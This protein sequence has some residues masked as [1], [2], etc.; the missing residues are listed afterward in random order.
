MM[1]DRFEASAGD[2]IMSGGDSGD[3]YVFGEGSG[4]DIIRENVTNILYGDVDT[5]EFG[6]GV[7]PTEVTVTAQRRGPDP[8]ARGSG[9][10]LTIDRRIRLRELVHLSRRRA[11]PLRRR[12]RIW[13][14]AD[15]QV[16]ARLD[17]RRRSSDRLR[18][19]R[20][21]STAAPA[22]TYLE[23]ATAA[24]PIASGFGSG[25]DIIRE[26]RH[27][28]QSRRRRPARSSAPAS[29]QRR[30]LQP[31]RQRSRRHHLVRATR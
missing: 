2:D 4:H 29:C 3:T 7:L 13:T 15:I 23:G 11:V 31:R 8:H 6:P 27:Q 19:R 28:F 14:K 10:T 20:H 18:Q 30:H 17:R 5:V 24:T 16:R 22:T 9:D 26:W 25:N 1:A 12:H 21:R